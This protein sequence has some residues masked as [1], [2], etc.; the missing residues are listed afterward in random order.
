MKKIFLLL[1]LLLLITACGKEE[2]PAQPVPQRPQT[3]YVP[4]PEPGPVS[5]EPIVSQPTPAP[6][7]PVPAPEPVT[8]PEPEPSPPPAPT[9][10]PVQTNSCKV[11]T[12]TGTLYTMEDV[13]QGK[14]SMAD[15][16]DLKKC[17]PYFS[18]DQANTEAMCCII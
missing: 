14:I 8:V 6:S 18:A 2:A 5:P 12:K 10:Q 3:F 1:A 4:P 17:Y 9:P 15:F 13:D 7:P 11:L 16:S